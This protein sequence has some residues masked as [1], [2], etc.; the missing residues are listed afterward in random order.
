MLRPEQKVLLALMAHHWLL[1]WNEKSWDIWKAWNGKNRNLKFCYGPFFKVEADNR[2]HESQKRV[3]S[4]NLLPLELLIAVTW[5]QLVIRS[6]V[7]RSAKVPQLVYFPGR[8]ELPKCSH[9]WQRTWSTVRELLCAGVCVCLCVWC[10]PVL[11]QQASFKKLSRVSS[12]SMQN[13]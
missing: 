9:A 5:V 6:Y 7:S 11:A 1:V 8:T 12:L 4:H 2:C 10:S 13:K 3:I